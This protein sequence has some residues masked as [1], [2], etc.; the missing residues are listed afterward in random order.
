ML[1]RKPKKG[2]KPD[3]KPLTK[4]EPV[5]SFFNFFSPPAVRLSLVASSWWWWWWAVGRGN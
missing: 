5:E 3:T 4:T 2:A 1:K